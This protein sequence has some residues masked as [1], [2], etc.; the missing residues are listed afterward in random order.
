MMKLKINKTYTKEPRPKIRIHKNK[1]WSWN[2]SN[3][4]DQTIIFEEEERK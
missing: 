2:I 1:D 4:K 3:K